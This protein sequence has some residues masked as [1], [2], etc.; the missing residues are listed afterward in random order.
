MVRCSAIENTCIQRGNRG[1]G[2]DGGIK[3]INVWHMVEIGVCYHTFGDA[4][5]ELLY[6]FSEV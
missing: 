4:L 2:A 1:S 3:L 6:L 5:A